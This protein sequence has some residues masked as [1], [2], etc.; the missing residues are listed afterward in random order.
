MEKKLTFLLVIFTALLLAF[1]IIMD[2]ADIKRD[3]TQAVTEVLINN[4]V[5]VTR[6]PSYILGKSRAVT[7]TCYRAT[8]GQCDATPFITANNSHIDTSRIDELR[9]LAVSRNLE[10]YYQM[11]DSVI[12]SGCRVNHFNGIWYI[13]DRMNLR[14]TDKIDFLISD[15]IQADLFKNVK[16]SKILLA[17]PI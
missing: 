12:V 6:I 14:F 11:D 8:V 15:S 7:A 16:I 5:A 2:R 1:A 9:W 17:Q 3:K 10:A 13:K 4:T